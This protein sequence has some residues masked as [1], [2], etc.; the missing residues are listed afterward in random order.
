MPQK[1]S[2]KVE[3]SP[4][5]NSTPTIVIDGKTADISLGG[6]YSTKLPDGKFIPGLID[7]DIHVKNKNNKVVIQLRSAMNSILVRNNNE[8]I[9]IRLDGQ[10]GKIILLNSDGKETIQF[11]GNSGDII[12]ENADCA[13][14]FDIAN[15]EDIHSG[16]VV[17]F[18]NEGKL[19]QCDKAYDN[20]VAGVISGSGET[21]PGIILGRQ[22]GNCDRVPLALM[23]KVFCKVDAQYGSVK[24]GDMLTTS[25]TPGFAMKA[26]DQSRAFGAIIGKA[27]G[28]M[29]SGC[30][31]LPIIVALQ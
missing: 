24:P 29:E 28:S 27:I 21:K 2:E 30:G 25:L 4:N 17:I 13:E 19:R 7:G 1:F 26:C 15:M 14:E 22:S 6:T 10:T 18:D 23:G 12:L 3:V 11:D 8:S 20:R 5:D 31:L 16:T 9:T